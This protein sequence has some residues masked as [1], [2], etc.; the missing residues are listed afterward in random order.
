MK[1]TFRLVGFVALALASIAAVAVAAIEIAG[2]KKAVSGTNAVS[3][4]APTNFPVVIRQ[5][6][7]PRVFTGLTNYAGQ[8]VTA[9]CASCHATTKS[10]PQLR[11]AADLQ[12]FH[13]GLKY[14]HGAL[15]CVS[16]HNDKNYNTLKLADGTSVEFPNVMQLCAQC[17][18]PQARDYRNGSHGGM[19][20]HWDLSKGPRTRN[21]CTDCHDPHAPQYP[22][23]MPVF[24]PR[25]RGIQKNSH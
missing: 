2:S 25:D 22:V 11:D 4:A 12:Q 13:Q 15:S 20:G 17:H 10:N 16:C 9:S 7:A 21:N 24:Q 18:G 14:N 1:S 5:P 19:N 8:P 6:S 3:T 23:V